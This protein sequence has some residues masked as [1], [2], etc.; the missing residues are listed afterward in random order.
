M[1]YTDEQRESIWQHVNK[2]KL[3]DLYKFKAGDVL[4]ITNNVNTPF[5]RYENVIAVGD[6]VDGIFETRPFIRVNVS[7]SETFFMHADR[8]APLSAIVS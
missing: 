2:R 5:K 4:I 7:D 8:C 1:D 3:A 6:T